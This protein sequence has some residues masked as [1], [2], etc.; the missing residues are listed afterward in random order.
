MLDDAV[1]IID[2][3]FKKQVKHKKTCVY[4]GSFF[5]GKGIEQIFR[6]AKKN[7]NTSFHIYGEKQYLRSNKKEENLKLFDY[8][9]YSKI[10]KILSRYEVALMPYQK[11]IK[12][13]KYTKKTKIKVL[14]N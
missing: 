3:N 11:K 9:H 8:V 14:Q 5:E 2:F 10:P 4:I 1:S 7:K 12:K 6:L 13:I